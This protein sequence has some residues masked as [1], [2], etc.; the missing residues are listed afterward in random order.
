MAN[1]TIARNTESNH[2]YGCTDFATNQLAGQIAA[3][4]AALDSTVVWDL[5][6]NPGY[7]VSIS[8]F[9]FVGATSVGPTP[10]T[11]TAWKDL[12]SPI[13]G[14]FMDQISTTL[15]R[16]TLYLSPPPGSLVFNIGQAFVMPDSNVNINVN[17]EGCA[18]VAGAGVAFR[19]NRPLD[20][21]V[22][23]DIEISPEL[24]ENIISSSVSDEVDE[25]RGILPS[26]PVGVNKNGSSTL[27]MS[28]I[29]STEFGYRY[30]SPPTLSFSD[31]NYHSISVV[32][33][34]GEDIVGT[35]FY[36][37]KRN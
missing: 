24:S 35:R 8:D 25:V 4:G 17:I 20:P 5:S 9:V 6:A 33:R 3:D 28:Y 36:I 27:L 16:I 10:L 13:L 2:V 37:Y 22:V 19:L 12:P 18:M 15:I 26:Q 29:V 11:Q 21:N 14:A 1:Y 31:P 30:S 7:S 23:T 32:Q 34:N